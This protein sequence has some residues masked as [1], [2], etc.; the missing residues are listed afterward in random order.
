M[1][2]VPKNRTDQRQGG[3]ISDNACGYATNTN[4]GP[5][6]ANS[7]IDWPTISDTWPNTENIINPDMRDVRL[8]YRLD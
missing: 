7:G 2:S 4:S 6:T 8:D 3:V 5:W 1:N